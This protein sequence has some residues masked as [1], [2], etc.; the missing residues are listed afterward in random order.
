MVCKAVNKTLPDGVKLSVDFEALTASTR[1]AFC[2]AL[3]EEIELTNGGLCCTDKERFVTQTILSDRLA[4][5][6]FSQTNY[7]AE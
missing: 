2:S 5:D 7:F 6:V 3:R 4:I 1:I